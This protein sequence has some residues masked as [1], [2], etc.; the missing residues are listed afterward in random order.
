M[1]T[2]NFDGTSHGV[3][4]TGTICG[5]PK[6]VYVSIDNINSALATRK[7]GFGRSSR[8]NFTDKV[9]FVGHES[10]TEFYTDGSDLQFFVANTSVETR[11]NITAVRTGHADLVGTI[12]YPNMTSRDIAEIASAR[13]SLCYVV[14]GCIC[15]QI[16]AKWGV[17]TSYFVKQIGNVVA[18]CNNYNQN[19]R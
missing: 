18:N 13:N 15:E 7:G 11:P 4:Y 19:N 3:G 5:I 17:E 10:E 2:F 14:L 1:I 8:Q 9:V 12:R 16:V 6:G